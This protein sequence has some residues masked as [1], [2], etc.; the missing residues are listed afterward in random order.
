[1][2]VSTRDIDANKPAG[3]IKIRVKTIGYFLKRYREDLVA[4]KKAKD[5]IEAQLAEYE[6]RL[7]LLQ[8]NLASLC[9]RSTPA[10][11]C[12]RST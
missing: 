2:R 8:E 7:Q 12:R 5:S 6:Q 11:P 4:A 1:M 9:G 3:S 10:A